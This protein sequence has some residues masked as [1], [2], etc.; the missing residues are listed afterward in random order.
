MVQGTWAQFQRIWELVD[1][2]ANYFDEPTGGMDAKRPRT[3]P[4]SSQELY[5]TRNT[6][7]SMVIKTL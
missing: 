6:Q 7:L 3:K 4:T 2:V 5:M 1:S